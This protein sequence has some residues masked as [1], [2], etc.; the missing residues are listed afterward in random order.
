MLKINLNDLKSKLLKRFFHYSIKGIYLYGSTYL[1]EST[2]ESDIDIIILCDKK[3]IC[4]REI[5]FFNSKEV[6]LNLLSIELLKKDAFNFE[7][8]S[9]FISKFINPFFTLYSLENFE[10][11]LKKMVCLFLENY[12]LGRLTSGK[13]Y[14]LDKFISIIYLTHINNFPNYLFSLSK[15]L[16]LPRKYKEMTRLKSFILSSLLISNKIILKKDSFV[17]IKKFCLNKLNIKLMDESLRVRWWYYYQKNRNDPTS[18][19]NYLLEREKDIS[20]KKKEV[21]KTYKKLINIANGKRTF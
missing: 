8:G 16:N 11:E 9:I 10:E 13:N 20:S 17:V 7:Y 19:M 1:G 6:H 12:I 4:E 14:N 21:E 3:G 2:K 15:W 5:F 18:I